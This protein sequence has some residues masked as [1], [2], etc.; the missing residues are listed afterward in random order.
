MIEPRFQGGK[1]K[2]YEDKPASLVPLVIIVL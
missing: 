1:P 2:V